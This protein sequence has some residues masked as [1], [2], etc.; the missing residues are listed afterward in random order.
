MPYDMFDRFT[1]PINTDCFGQGG[2]VPADPSQSTNTTPT[3][4]PQNKKRP[5]TGAL[6]GSALNGFNRNV[7]GGQQRKDILTSNPFE[8]IGTAVGT[9]LKNRQAKNADSE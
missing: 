9:Y 8:Q 6:V 5:R 4:D 2:N 7:F 3:P 1:P